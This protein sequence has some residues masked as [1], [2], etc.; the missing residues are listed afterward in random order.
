MSRGRRPPLAV[1]WRKVEERRSFLQIVAHLIALR[2]AD[3]FHV[4]RLAIRIRAVPELHHAGG[5]GVGRYNGKIR[6]IRQITIWDVDQLR[7]DEVGSA[8]DF[9]E[10]LIGINPETR[11]SASDIHFKLTHCNSLTT[12]ARAA[13]VQASSILQLNPGGMMATRK[14]LSTDDQ[15][16]RTELELELETAS[17]KSVVSSRNGVART[18]LECGGGSL[19]T[20]RFTRHDLLTPG[21]NVDPDNRFNDHPFGAIEYSIGA[22]VA[23][24]MSQ[25]N[26]DSLSFVYPG[27]P[28]SSVLPPKVTNPPLPPLP[29]FDR[30]DVTL[31][32]SRSNTVNDKGWIDFDIRF[33]YPEALTNHSTSIAWEIRLLYPQ[34][35]F[36]NDAVVDD[37]PLMAHELLFP[38][39]P[40]GSLAAIHDTLPNPLGQLMNVQYSALF[41]RTAGTNLINGVSGLAFSG[42]DEIGQRKS[43]SYQRINST[44]ALGCLLHLPIHLVGLPPAF[45]RPTVP[46]PDKPSFTLSGGDANGF[47]GAL[48][49]FRLRAFQVDGVCPGARVGWTDAASVYRSW[50]MTRKPSFFNKPVRTTHGPIDRVSPH[51]VISNYS[52]DGQASSL[53]HPVDQ[54]L[55][56]HPAKEG[57]SDTGTPNE[58]L[59]D[60][61]M[62]MR[63]TMETQTDWVTANESEFLASPPAASSR[64]PNLID[65]FARSKGG[66]LL[67]S[68]CSG[69]GWVGWETLSSSS[70]KLIKDTPASASWDKN[71]I[72]VLARGADDTL[73]HK[74]WIS[75]IGWTN[76][77]K[78]L[79]QPGPTTPVVTVASAPAMASR[80]SNRLDCF[81]RGS[82]GALWHTEWSAG[83]QA[84]KSWDKPPPGI[85][86]APAAVAWSADR[87]DCLVRGSD[88]ALYLRSLL[89]NRLADWVGVGHPPGV[90]LKADPAIASWASNRLD[91]F[92][93]GTDNGLWHKCFNGTIFTDWERLGITKSSPAAASWGLHRVDCFMLD[94]ETVKYKWLDQEVS[95]EA[96]IW[97]HEMGSTYH[98]L[99][100][101]PPATNVVSGDEDR[102]RNALDALNSRRIVPTITTDPLLPLFNRGRYRGHLKQNVAGLWEDCIQVGFPESI[103]NY[104]QAHSG[105]GPITVLR[106]KDPNPP[107]DDNRVF[108]VEPQNNFKAQPD[109]PDAKDLVNHYHR[110]D[111]SG[112]GEWEGALSNRLY[113]ATIRPICL[114]PEVANLY[115]TKWAHAV[116][117]H[118][119]RLVEFMKV[120]W[121][122]L[123]CYDKTHH[124]LSSSTGEYDNVMGH[125]S[126]YVQRLKDTWQRLQLKGH[127]ADASINKSADPAFA[128][129]CEF[130][131]DEMLLPYVD[132]FYQRSLLFQYLYSSKI[133]AKMGLGGIESVHLHPGY[134][135][136]PVPGIVVPP[137]SDL[138]MTQDDSEFPPTHKEWLTK[139]KGILTYYNISSGLA[140]VNYPTYNEDKPP[141]TYT[142]Q[143]CLQNYFN[144]RSAIFNLGLAAVLGERIL[145][146]STWLEPPNEY[147]AE[148]IAFAVKAAKL[149]MTFKE[150]FRE[151]YWLG[152]AAITQG[153]K[154][155]WAWE[156]PFRQFPDVDPLVRKLYQRELA[157]IPGGDPKQLTVRLNI[158]D[159]ISRATDTETITPL[160]FGQQNVTKIV[161]AKLVSSEKIQHNIWQR[162]GYF[163]RELLYL[164]A[165]V[166]NSDANAVEF[167]YSK[168]LDQ[169]PVNAPWKR[170]LYAFTGDGRNAPVTNNI[171][172][173]VV[174]GQLETVSMP[175]RSLLAVRLTR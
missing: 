42:T 150:F 10:I 135:E 3:H 71:R 169:T 27:L 129:T 116:F 155:L 19:F 102:F 16:G 25:P 173:E 130:A 147:L 143:R 11:L 153:Q 163:G 118:G 69:N 8:F 35:H 14:F 74:W 36:N 114:T 65:L 103:E 76:D 37:T 52:I 160:N 96:Q 53:G 13:R 28:V 137:A 82:D 170:T 159:F 62:R 111:P 174:L 100:G 124:H 48:M 30:I 85:A 151:G 81:V 20:I 79:G 149:H 59:Q 1:A 56:V 23:N 55:E 83:W 9:V 67:H 88:N 91:I 172:A 146:S 134:K 26:T 58:S 51:T 110:H 99:G 105:I 40:L 7:R 119:A 167:Q 31:I 101:Y 41:K 106:I 128:L 32:F 156:A 43:V 46:P 12:F 166:G 95:I 168:G 68:G 140:P 73:L 60:V 97:G 75:G 57:Q 113:D 80:G 161:G 123:A 131:P 138:P 15:F 158:A 29:A 92:A 21:N 141:G 38:N 54:W 162:D 139:S 64:Q 112:P 117:T 108:L 115:L 45:V 125:G 133:S 47:R 17:V 165:N 145:F 132:E 148:V 72:D 18:L 63:Q 66:K 89:P 77:W 121:G 107:P 164:F 157:Q 175:K 87:V 4:C 126:W 152:Q 109:V 5:G 6:Q 127:G 84:W 136:T 61:L 22:G 44:S 120:H 122:G 39:G 154:L 49:K 98:Y 70:G 2:L 78:V 94:G 144:L 171:P 93:W 34:I 33:T 90:N 24:P 86:S 104:Q 142:Y 50:L